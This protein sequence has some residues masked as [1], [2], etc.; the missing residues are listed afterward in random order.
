MG[1]EALKVFGLLSSYFR[2]FVRC[3]EMLPA[4]FELLRM[5]EEFAHPPDPS[6]QSL[7]P[8]AEE[9]QREAAPQVQT[10][11]GILFGGQLQVCF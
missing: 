4:T 1:H 6:S 10:S 8:V 2:S 7:V 5:I 11:G 9:M 3:E